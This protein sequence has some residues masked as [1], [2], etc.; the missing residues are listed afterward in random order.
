M[1]V[2]H[3][4]VSEIADGPDDTLVRP[5]DWNAEHVIEDG[6]ITQAMLAVALQQALLPAG[7]VLPFG[8]AAAPSGF[9]LCN[10]A[11]L[12]RA[13]FPA[14]F[15]AIGTAFG[16]ADGTHFNVPDMRQRFARG[17]GAAEVLGAAGGSATHTHADHAQLTHAGAA[18]ADHPAHT[19]TV[20]SNVAVGDHAAHTHTVTSNVAVGDHA[21]HTHTVTSNVAVGDHAAH[22]HNVTAAGTNSAPTF[23]GSAMA[24][25]AHEL[26]F[27][28]VAGGTGALGMLAP[29]I[30]GTGTSRARESVSAAPTASTTSAAVELSQAVSA[31]TPAGTVS[32]PTFTGSQVASGNPSATLAHSVTNN[33]VT[34]G[35]P[36]ATLSHSVTNNQVT[37]DN[38][39]AT[40]SHSV[41]NNQVT[42]G[43]PS[44]TLSHNV[45]QPNAH[46]I[47]SHDSPNSEPPYVL[48]NYIIKA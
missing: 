17:K 44:A 21:A 5:S 39:S 42:S 29:S 31:G 27:Q 26:P 6:T 45:T 8:G 24:T 9:L 1:A 2:K 48:L 7:V 40:L 28:K 25:H 34:S 4:F 32:A 41:T 19:H 36:S 11:S 37:S 23:T 46:T 3:Q 35:N 15:A 30:F 10:G 47:S 16:A 18:V 14:L 43:N 12:L 38:P 22:T 13:D 33:Q 20:T